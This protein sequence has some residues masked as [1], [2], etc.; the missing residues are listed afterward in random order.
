MRFVVLMVAVP[1]LLLPSGAG[2]GGNG[3]Q[4]K[5]AHVSTARAKLLATRATLIQRKKAMR[6][7][8]RHELPAY[9]E[10]L[11]ARRAAYEMNKQ[12]YEKDLI[13]KSELDNSERALINTRLDAERIRQLIAE[14]DRALSLAE[15]AAQREL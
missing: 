6:E 7:H 14:D 3:A 4:K 8:L 5:A 15:A 1:A 13:S 10:R 2:A 12:L 9:E 11:E